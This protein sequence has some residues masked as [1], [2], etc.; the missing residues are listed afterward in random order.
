ML[1]T[2]I[3]C[4]V[5]QS[6]AVCLECHS[7]RDLTKQVKSRAVP[8][9]FS[10]NAFATS[11]HRTINCIDC[12]AVYKKADFPHDNIK[13]HPVDCST[14]HQQEAK[15]EAVSLHGQAAEKGDLLAPRCQTCHGAHDIL[16]VRHA[17]SAVNPIRV[18]FVCGKCH[19][20]GAPVQ[21]QRAIPVDRILKNYTESIHGE[22][23]LKKGLTVAA[24]C[25]SCHTPHHIL[26]HTDPRSSIN[27]TNIATTCAA[28]HTQLEQVHRKIIEGELW[29]KNP[30]SLPVCVDCHQPHKLRKVFYENGLA[31]KDCLACHAKPA[32]KSSHDGRSLRV[33]TD[34]IKASK[35]VKVTCAQCHTE[36]KASKERACAT[37][38]AKVNCGACHAEMAQQY[39]GS[40][41]GQLFAQGELN[42]PTCVECHGGHMVRGKK[43]EQ[44]PIFA[45]NIPDLCARCHRDGGKAAV[46][47]RGPEKNITGRY[48]ESIHG[49][50]LYKS[51][52]TIAAT[53]T[54]C[55]TSHGERPADDPTSSV[56]RTNII[57]TCAKCHSGMEKLFA[58]SIHS[59]TVS[60]STKRLPVCNDCHIAHAMSC[61]DRD[62]F[63]LDTMD[64]CG[65]CH[66]QIAEDYF[67]TYH[68]KVSKLGYTKTAK[69]YDCHGAHDVLP[70]TNPASHLSTTH[71]LATCQKCHPSATPKFTGYLTHADHHNA[72]K[73]PWLF[74][75]F[76]AMTAL[77]VGVFAVSGLHTLLWLPRTIQMCRQHRDEFKAIHQGRQFTRFSRFERLSHVV[78]IVTFMGLT[79]TGL[80]LKFSY[81]TWAVVMSHFFGG[82]Q[83]AG[84]IHRLCAFFMF[85][86]YIAHLTDLFVFK[87]R[88]KGSLNNL[89]FGPDSLIFNKR[90]WREFL[91]SLRWFVGRGERPK[92]GRW[93]YWEKFDYMAVFWGI[94]VIGSTGLVLWFPEFFTR[95]LPGWAINVA[96]I[97]HSDE[98][99]LA[100][101]FI[102]TIHFFNTHLRPEKFPMDTVIFTGRMDLEELRVDKPDEYERMVASG[103]LEQN[104]SE[105]LP[106]VV[107][108]AVRAFAWLALSLGVG[109]V[110]WIIRAL[111][112]AR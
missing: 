74:C 46:R 47:Y 84:Y 91:A 78:L 76:W 42:A 56:N 69:C 110:V 12:H 25:V 23:L 66:Q 99:L 86:L 90:D 94:V 39:Q 102:F 96:T 75:T 26:P 17:D 79:L 87:R 93:T 108:R 85:L 53:C 32:I 48:R 40:R 82:F 105:R 20:E 51:G 5:A 36:V 7:D 45:L 70:A 6:N 106:P 95:L 55:H 58:M 67:G 41:H 15:Q 33:D 28:C 18:P 97:I 72:Q 98:A 73:Y 34:E 13:P 37:I 77:L 57:R 92:Y 103:K 89:F 63:R 109:A 71:A 8:L 50:G 80:T 4:A 88:A 107:M 3:P 65:K 24:S 68:G 44:A 62:S 43:D 101:G 81:T 2:L 30:H 64:L 16:P 54:D 35:H 29:Q 49:K 83:S 52:L 11:V 59:A 100:V 22:G 14:C 21:E 111:V 104:M 1:P 31:D 27:A 10:T 38:K 60:H 9:A 19:C 112:F 61:T